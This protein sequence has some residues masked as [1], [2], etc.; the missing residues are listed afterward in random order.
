MPRI[1][2]RHSPEVV[3]FVNASLEALTLL[4]SLW[5]IRSG[6]LAVGARWHDRDGAALL[7]ALNERVAVLP[8]VGKH[9]R[10]GPSLPQRWGWRDLVGRP[11]GEKNAHRAACGLRRQVDV[12]RQAAAGTPQRLVLMP[13]LPAVD[14]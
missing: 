9:L 6:T 13:P 7:D 1:A 12:H 10:R 11:A 8:L 5:I 2:R 4:V 14:G 3:E